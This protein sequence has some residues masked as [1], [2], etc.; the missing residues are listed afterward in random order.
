M[1]PLSDAETDAALS[2]EETEDRAGEAAFSPEATEDRAGEA[3]FSPEG[4]VE[5]TAFAL[6]E[7]VDR[8][9]PICPEDVDGEGAFAFGI[10]M[11]CL[12]S[13][14]QEE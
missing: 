6:D 3:A 7:T 12:A 5:P 9:A 13:F 2:P 11:D 10:A 14:L 4:E 1:N 8:A